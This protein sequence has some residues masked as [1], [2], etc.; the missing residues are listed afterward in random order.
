MPLVSYAECAAMFRKIAALSLL[1]VSTAAFGDSTNSTA[2]K[3]TPQVRT[4]AEAYARQMLAVIGYIKNGYVR[5][6]DRAVLVEAAIAGLYEAVREPLP[7][8][9]KNDLA[10]ARAASE[11]HYILLTARERLGDVEAIRD[12]LAMLASLKALPRVLDPYCGMPTPAELRRSTNNEANYG[13]GIELD[14]PPEH[15]NPL[16]DL[17]GI[18]RAPT[19]PRGPFRILTVMPGS[20]AQRAGLRPSDLITHIAGQPT[21]GETSNIVLRRLTMFDGEGRSGTVALTVKRAGQVKP[22]QVS[23]SAYA[24]TPEW[25]YGVRRSTDN[26]WNFMID[27]QAK[28]GYIRLGFI[29]NSAPP[30]VDTAISE[31]L[32][33]GMKGLLF[34]LRDCPGGYVDPAIA[35]AGLFIRDGTI[36]TVRDRGQQEQRHRT[37]G[38]QMPL[39]KTAIVVLVNGNTTGGGEMIAAALQDHDLAKICGQRTFGKGSVQRTQSVSEIGYQFKLTTGLFTRP[40]GK[41]LHRFPDSKPQD[42]WGVRPDNGFE[43]PLP[44]D[45]HK[46]LKQWHTELI[47]RPGESREPLALDDPDSDPV[48]QFALRKLREMV[49]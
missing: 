10:R 18:S 14:L 27:P 15:V 8:G 36:A 9:L 2:G 45:L 19:A 20:P 38:R 7:S 35:I 6:V 33:A 40:N 44:P 39:E 1:F 12:H 29:D 41:N 26:Q 16:S 22:I 4:Q 48:R 13:T 46:Q 34:D 17:D 42:D 31:L 3:S 43:L 23:L 11:F 30:Q 28:I 47:L 37:R 21:D 32:G 24:F 25:V 49:K 5:P